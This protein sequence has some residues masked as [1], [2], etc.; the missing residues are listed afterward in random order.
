MEIL[1]VK[2]LKKSYPGFCLDNVSFNVRE[3]E[4]M[5]FIGRNGAGKTTT[6][7]S[8]LNLVHPDGGE[9]LFFGKRFGENETE[10]KSKIGF[11]S[12][13]VDCYPRKRL[14]DISD[15]TRRFYAAWDDETYRRYLELFELDEAK[16]PAQLSAG[17]RVKYNLACALSHNA[18]LLILDE[19]TSGLDP[20]S[21]AELQD[22]F[23]SLVRGQ[24]VSILFSTHITSDLEK[25]ADRITYIK[26]GRI[27]ASE[28]LE[29]FVGRYS[30]LKLGEPPA[31]DK[32]ALLIGFKPAKNGFSAL[33]EN[34]NVPAFSCEALPASLEDIMVHMEGEAGV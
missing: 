24:G 30:V 13:G 18:R 33:A 23:L 11:V 1:S 2:N 12:G 16:T 7:K 22:I 29:S 5:G 34:K 6:L 32:K 3:G 31:E 9:V 19:P 4:I 10:I 20:V 25:C 28:E 27:V 17:M 15:V 14:R 26:S 21:R 8:L